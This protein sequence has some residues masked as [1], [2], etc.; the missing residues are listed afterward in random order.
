MYK[1][2]SD[3]NYIAAIIVYISSVYAVL[4]VGVSIKFVN[5]FLVLIFYLSRSGDVEGVIERGEPLFV[6]I[7]NSGDIAGI[8]IAI[9]GGASG[10]LLKKII[11]LKSNI[12]GL[13]D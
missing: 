12:R 3:F 10:F 4:F 7:K 13:N 9:L 2:E 1:Y 8:T 5:V 6:V 11:D